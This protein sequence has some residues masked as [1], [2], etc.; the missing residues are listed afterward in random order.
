[1]VRVVLGTIQ[2]LTSIASRNLNSGI[3]VTVFFFYENHPSVFI[4]RLNDD[5]MVYDGFSY[6]QSLIS[7]LAGV[8][9]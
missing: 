2:F 6:L 8:E 9:R 3:T 7:I 1:M 5:Q 4:I